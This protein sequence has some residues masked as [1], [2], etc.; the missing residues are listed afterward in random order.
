MAS[1]KWPVHGQVM[2]DNEQDGGWALSGIVKTQPLVALMG[3]GCLDG[4]RSCVQAGR[5]EDQREPVCFMSINKWP[6]ES[7]AGKQ[8]AYFT[9]TEKKGDVVLRPLGGSAG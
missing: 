8:R 3:K 9:N 4:E 2:E 1:H 6:V 5:Q 7:L